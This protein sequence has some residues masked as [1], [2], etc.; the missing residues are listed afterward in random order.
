MGL[1]QHTTNS[2]YTSKQAS[3]SRLI[4]A[5]VGGSALKLLFSVMLAGD[6]RRDIVGVVVD[7]LKSGTEIAERRVRAS[8][9]QHLRS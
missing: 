3:H 4:V 5:I 2:V 8:D 6:Y 1:L 7:S 9:L